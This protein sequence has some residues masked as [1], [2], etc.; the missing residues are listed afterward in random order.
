M[1]AISGLSAIT[2]EKEISSVYVNLFTHKQMVIDYLFS[3]LPENNNTSLTSFTDK[4]T[5]CLH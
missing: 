2:S 5:F 1:S 4:E 3:T